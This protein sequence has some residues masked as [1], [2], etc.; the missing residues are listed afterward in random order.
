MEKEKG[1]TLGICR[2]Q[3]QEEI[4]IE[5]PDEVWLKGGQWHGARPLNV[6]HGLLH[7]VT[8]SHVVWLPLFE[9]SDEQGVFEMKLTQAL[10]KNGTCIVAYSQLGSLGG[11]EMT[12]FPY[13]YELMLTN[14][15]M[16]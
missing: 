3:D 6:N 1:S 2:W 7:I 5:E 16:L 9:K 10:R 4:S 13:G 15:I 14:D 11:S 8:N 12:L